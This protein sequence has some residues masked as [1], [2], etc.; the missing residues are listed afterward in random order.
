MTNNF[1]DGGEFKKQGGGLVTS[2]NGL[3]VPAG[4]LFLQNTLNKSINL[5]KL[6]KRQDKEINDK[7]YDELINLASTKSI[8]KNKKLTKREK[9]K[10]IKKTRKN[11]KSRK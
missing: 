11:K 2:M 9:K 7:T 5:E 6:Y 8:K 10:L 3:I 1:I 4:L